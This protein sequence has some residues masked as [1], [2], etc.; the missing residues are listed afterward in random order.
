MLFT[1]RIFLHIYASALVLIFITPLFAADDNSSW[2]F[3]V[4]PDTQWDSQN[5]PFHGV[6]VHIIDAINDEF[7]RRKIDFV[8]QVGDLAEK[9][10]NIAFQTRAAHNK[11]LAEAGIKF[12]PLR[13]NHDSDNKA[14]AV[15][16]Y[17]AAFPNLPGTPGVGGS[18]PNLPGAEGMTYS[19]THKG[20]KF[21]LL[22]T[23]P[24][25]ASKVQSGK[26]Y[27]PGDYLPW[28]ESE[29]KKEDH[30]FTLVF[31]HKNLRGQFHKENIFG[32]NPDSNP[33]MQNAFIACLQQNG[34]RY[35]ISGHD[36]MYARSLIESLD[37]KSEIWQ[38]IS[39]NASA[40]SYL[41]IPSLVRK[42]ELPLGILYTPT[43]SL[44]LDDQ[45]K[46]VRRDLMSVGFLIIRV[47]TKRIL[48]EYF[49]AE[50][51]GEHPQRPVW[52][53]RDSFGYTFDHSP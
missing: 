13:G 50:S 39:G 29:L 47:D 28:I 36:H 38:I 48:F 19:F 32:M 8:I 30:R 2:A 23:F 15:A 37:G 52:K 42:R 21:I 26:A 24:L 5:A 9:P 25:F 12:Y 22:D 17:K 31:A 16:R 44:L 27:T 49:S 40:K 33:E 11:A 53:L 51:F 34:V 41:P 43:L 3:G 1:R 4:I 46:T 7:I 35:F 20:G 14:E 18:S 10:T 45:K 6:A